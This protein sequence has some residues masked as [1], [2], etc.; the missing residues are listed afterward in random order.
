[1][2]KFFTTW[3]CLELLRKRHSRFP[4]EKQSF[5][6]IKCWK[7]DMN[8]AG[9]LTQGRVEM[10]SLTLSGFCFNQGNVS[11]FLSLACV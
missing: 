6:D 5:V 9:I 10:I 2:H 3:K 1:M 8:F 11:L 4:L 7:D